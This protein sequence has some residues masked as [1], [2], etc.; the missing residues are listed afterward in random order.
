MHAT[1]LQELSESFSADA[2]PIRMELEGR[3]MDLSG[4]AAEKYE[5]WR[6]LLRKLY[7]E[8]TGFELAP[9]TPPEVHD[10]AIAVP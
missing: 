9:A 7:V 4:T 5:T 8:E 10:S 6:E 1:A 2:R 3:V